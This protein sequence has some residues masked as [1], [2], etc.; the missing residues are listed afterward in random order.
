[1]GRPNPVWMGWAQSLARPG[2]MIT[3]VFFPGGPNVKRLELLKEVRPQATTFGYLM[4]ATNP[5]NPMFGRVARDAAHAL[6]IKVEIVQVKEPSEFA[7]AFDRLVS[8][9]VEGIVIMPDPVLSSNAAAIAKLARLHRLPSV[10]DGFFFADA[11]GLFA[12]STNYDAMARRSA[13]YVDQIIKGISPGNLPAEQA[14]AWLRRNPAYRHLG[15]RQVISTSSGP[16]E[17][18]SR[19]GT[20]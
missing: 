2:G 18:A 6:G 5:G 11:G 17:R 4:N 9:G 12:Y 8:L 3:G 1:M 15:P 10:G 19:H 13:W 20:A 16:G 7:D 14:R